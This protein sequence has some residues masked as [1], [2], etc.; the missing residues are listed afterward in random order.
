MSRLNAPVSNIMYTQGWPPGKNP[1]SS[2][3]IMMRKNRYLRARSDN[4]T[5]WRESLRSIMNRFLFA[6]HAENRA[7]SGCGPPGGL[8]QNA[9]FCASPWCFL[10]SSCPSGIC[11]AL[12]R[13]SICSSLAPSS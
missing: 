4:F 2:V 8:Q 5:F 12:H 1:G 11:F 7:P 9:N 3:A 6:K 10:V 13:S